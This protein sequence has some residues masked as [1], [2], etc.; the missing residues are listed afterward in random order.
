MFYK[1]LNSIINKYTSPNYKHKCLI[2]SIGTIK[3]TKTI[4]KLQIISNKL[5]ITSYKLQATSYKLHAKSY[6]L[7]VTSYM[8]QGKSY[9]LKVKSNK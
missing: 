5:P 3:I 1:H 8:L 6:K 7:K 2:T 9:K 4:Y